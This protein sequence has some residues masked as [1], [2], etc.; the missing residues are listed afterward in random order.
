MKL[1][2]IMDGIVAE[3]IRLGH[4]PYNAYRRYGEI[5][6]PIRHFCEA[7]GATD[8]DE[9]TI[10]E[11]VQLTYERYQNG[12]IKRQRCSELT[13]AGRKIIH[14]A[15]TGTY[16][17]SPQK[18][19]TRYE[20]N[21]Y[22]TEI[23]NDF[24]S[25]EDFHPNTADDIVWVTRR[26]FH[27][28]LVQQIE[29]ISDTDP[30]CIQNYMH[31][32]AEQMKSSSVYNIHL[33]LKKLYV[34]LHKAGYISDPYT[35]FFT[36]KICR[37][38]RMFPAANP[39]SVN[40]VLNV[41]D[42]QTS[43]G[44]RDYAIIMMGYV[45][46]MRAVDIARLKLSDIHWQEGE[47]RFAQKKTGNPVALPLTTD[48]GKAL[49]DYILNGRPQ[50]DCEE[51]FLRGTPPFFPLKD[52][53]AI[54]DQYNIY[55]KRAGIQRIAGDGLGFHSLRRATGKNLVTSGTPVNIVAQV[56]GDSNIDSTRKYISLD[57]EHL[58]EC[59]LDF[60]G[61]EPGATR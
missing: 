56:L 36:F 49:E 31:E 20:L 30:V 25:S 17:W 52:P 54:G 59:A 3:M 38:S 53:I 41:I 21:V 27:W 55:L 50:S 8:Y 15:R 61:I 39:E 12:E 48:V 29:K 51:I 33:Y 44:K 37:E 1:E 47:I 10:Q 28:L 60:T 22:Y 26:Y 42:T 9:A 18:R 19:G 43:V 40:A 4:S 24:L 35:E 11:F 2:E 45:L 58:A 23:L 16:L 46:G 7:Q 34:F 6:L 13:C 14:Y 57:S 32:C 5:Y